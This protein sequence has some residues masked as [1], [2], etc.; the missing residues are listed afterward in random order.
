MHY[1]LFWLVVGAAA[2]M[3]DYQKILIDQPSPAN[4]RE[5]LF[6]L[7]RLPHV[8]GVANVTNIILKHMRESLKDIAPATFNTH[9]F[10][11]LSQLPN[12]TQVWTKATEQ[13]PPLK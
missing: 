9:S 10:T 2:A 4:L 3:D 12:I 11:A 6:D 7:T 8:F 5:A 13:E 1:L